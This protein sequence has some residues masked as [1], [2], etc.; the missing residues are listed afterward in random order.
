[1][2]DDWKLMPTAAVAH[3]AIPTPWADLD[4]GTA[5]LIGLTRAR[6]LSD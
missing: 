2:P 4:G 3:L 1:M 6:S 5:E